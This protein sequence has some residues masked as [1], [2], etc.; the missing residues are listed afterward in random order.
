M[1]HLEF[2]EEGT[3]DTSN[4]ECAIIV[5]LFWPSPHLLYP[6]SQAGVGTR[7]KEQFRAPDSL[8]R[9]RQHPPAAAGAIPARS[10]IWS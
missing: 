1:S 4:I 2:A 9:N 6:G 7:L 3:T 5:V 8:C 10:R